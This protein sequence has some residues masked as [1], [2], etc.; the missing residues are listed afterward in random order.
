M[1][2]MQQLK[3]PFCFCCALALLSSLICIFLQGKNCFLLFV[4]VWMLLLGR[5][6]GFYRWLGDVPPTLTSLCSSVQGPDQT[7]PAQELSRRMVASLAQTATPATLLSA[8]PSYF[9]SLAMAKAFHLAL[10]MSSYPKVGL[11][12]RDSRK[13]AFEDSVG[14]L[15]WKDLVLSCIQSLE[16]LGLRFFIKVHMIPRSCHLWGHLSTTWN[17]CLSASTRRT[18]V[19]P[20][21]R[22]YCD[23]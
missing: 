22:E 18:F 21:F 19:P 23:H 10:A 12:T 3:G 13:T 14:P 8:K 16:C 20:G 2:G 1:F 11:A 9:G 17:S 6:C 7:R 5:N 15:T 4:G